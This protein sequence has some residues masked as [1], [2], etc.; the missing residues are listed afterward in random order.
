MKDEVKTNC[1]HFILHPSAFILPMSRPLAA[2]GSDLLNF[3]ERSIIIRAASP[4]T[5]SGA[6]D[7]ART[8]AASDAQTFF[9]R[10]RNSNY[11]CQHSSHHH[12]APRLHVRRGRT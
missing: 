3:F 6:T 12:T 2:G 7:D 5:F 9:P 10:E 8:S 1:F 4:A 11:L